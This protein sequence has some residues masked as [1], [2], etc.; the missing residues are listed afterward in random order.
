MTEKKMAPATRPI[1][2]KIIQVVMASI[3]KFL[4]LSIDLF[5][6][7]LGTEKR[8]LAAGGEVALLFVAHLFYKLY[9]IR[10]IHVFCFFSEAAGV[11]PG[12]IRP[13]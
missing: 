8:T 7:V 3:L 1:M 9:K 13:R 4:N 5:L 12:R 10:V 11:E 6:Q 2:A